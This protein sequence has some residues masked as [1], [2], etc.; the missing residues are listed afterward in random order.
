MAYK[1][2]KVHM[3][4][5]HS[6]QHESRISF[7]KVLKFEAC[8]DLLIWNAEHGFRPHNCNQSHRNNHPLE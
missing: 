3:V 6:T 5:L 2:A 8:S 1:L 7:S 4:T